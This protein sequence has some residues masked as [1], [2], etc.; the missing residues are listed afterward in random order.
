MFVIH[1]DQV[2]AFARERRAAFEETAARLVTARLGRAVTV[3]AVHASVDRALEWRVE[4][5]P[6]VLQWVALEQTAE[7][8]LVERWPWAGAVLETDGLA[9][10]GKM[11]TLVRAAAER[12]HDVANVDFLGA[13]KS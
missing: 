13:W 5:E 10:I 7:G 11:R 12:G 8:P 9:A 2:E 4:N 3:E 1:R 6:E